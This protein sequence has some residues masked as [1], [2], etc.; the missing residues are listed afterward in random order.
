MATTSSLG[1]VPPFEKRRIHRNGHS[2][3][4]KHNLGNLGRRSGQKQFSACGADGATLVDPKRRS[5]FRRRFRDLPELASGGKMGR[6]SRWGSPASRANGT[7]IFAPAPYQS[8]S[9]IYHLYPGVDPRHYSLHTTPLSPH[10]EFR[11]SS[12]SSVRAKS[13][14]TK[15]SRA[16]PFVSLQAIIVVNPHA[17]SSLRCSLKASLS[18][19][20]AVESLKPPFKR[21]I[22]EWNGNVE[23]KETCVGEVAYDPEHPGYKDYAPDWH[24]KNKESPDKTRFRSR[25]W[26]RC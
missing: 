9:P 19:Y 21:A 23:E 4:V 7:R 25:S 11:W 14:P 10:A 16:D 1:K 2:K 8:T 12:E 5:G 24:A 15:T 3:A 18:R 6:K 22:R 17:M 20:L 13:E 26:R